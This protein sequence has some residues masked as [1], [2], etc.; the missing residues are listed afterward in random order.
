MPGLSERRASTLTRISASVSRDSA[1]RRR[2]RS[3]RSPRSKP[4]LL[5]PQTTRSTSFPASSRVSRSSRSKRRSALS[6][7][8]T[9]PGWTSAIRVRSPVCSGRGAPAQAADPAAATATS[10]ATA[11]I[12]ARR[13]ATSTATA[14]FSAT[15]RKLGSHTPPTDASRSAASTCHW[16]APST[17][18]GP[19]SPC[20]ERISSI[21]SHPDGTTSSAAATRRPDGEPP[22]VR[23]T[24]QPH[25]AHSA[26]SSAARTNVNT[27]RL[28][29]SQWCMTSMNP[30]PPHQPS[31]AARRP[32]GAVRTS[33]SQGT[34]AT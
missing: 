1:V 6:G 9:T 18:H 21:V 30:N 8:A 31:N 24:S 3:G 12:R 25:G 5:S 4:T 11:G 7:P 23:R 2:A 34:R 28:G 20:H 15:T 27:C 32:V 16:L 33:S 13:T 10:P 14:T 29:S 22:S 19:P 26:P 17:P